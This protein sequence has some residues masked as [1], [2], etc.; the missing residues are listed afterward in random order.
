MCVYIVLFSAWE[1]GAFKKIS[2][3]SSYAKKVIF[4]SSYKQ[5]D[6]ERKFFKEKIGQKVLASRTEE[7]DFENSLKPRS[8]GFKLLDKAHPDIVVKEFKPFEKPEKPVLAGMDENMKKETIKVYNE[9]LH[10]YKESLTP[11]P[12]SEKIPQNPEGPRP[13]CLVVKENFD[14]S[15]ASAIV[16]LKEPILEGIEQY[17]SNSNSNQGKILPGKVNAKVVVVYGCDGYNAPSSVSNKNDRDVPVGALGVD[18]VISDIQMTANT[19]TSTEQQKRKSNPVAE[20]DES[21]G[22]ESDGEGEDNKANDSSGDGDDKKGKDS[23]SNSDWTSAED[24][25]SEDEDFQISSPGGGSYRSVFKEMHCNSPFVAHPLLIGYD[26]ENDHVR[27][28]FK[29]KKLHMEGHCPN[30]ILPPPPLQK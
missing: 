16:H 6:E 11:P 27:D 20:S 8:T 22:D 23:S 12:V 10:G 5:H 9:K 1:T 29:K 19:T 30:L 24:D 2:P 25:S 15:L 21:D 18:F 26:D 13:L 28:A 4:G 14:N 7:T 3:G 17:N